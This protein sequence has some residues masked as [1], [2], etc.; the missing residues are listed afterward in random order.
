MEEI[1]NKIFLKE[2]NKDKKSTGKIIVGQRNQH[3]K[4]YFF[5]LHGIKMKQK[6]LIFNKQCI[7]KNAFHENKRPISIDKINIKRI[8]L[9]KK[10]FYGKK[11][12]I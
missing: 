7:N 1:V 6:A 2:I 5:S 8:V 3:K 10:Y 4:F 11:R 9:P 12:F